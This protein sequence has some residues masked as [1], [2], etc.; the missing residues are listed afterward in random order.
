MKSFKQY[1]IETH[2]PDAKHFWNMGVFNPNG[3]FSPEGRFIDKLDKVPEE[4]PKR[5]FN[6]S[7]GGEEIEGFFGIKSMPKSQSIEYT[8]KAT[9]FGHVGPVW[10]KGSSFNADGSGDKPNHTFLQVE[11]KRITDPGRE[12]ISFVISRVNHKQIADE[13][14]H[15]VF[16]R[17][18]MNTEHMGLSDI[19]AI[20]PH[21]AENLLN[22]H[23][24]TVLPH[25]PYPGA[26]K[27]QTSVE[28]FHYPI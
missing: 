26:N 10:N 6:P 4:L 22:A 21:D 15:H 3:R 12:G 23:M 14:I 5:S 19:F 27:Q 17:D 28:E 25:Y 20:H 1:L 8:G 7:I 13:E 11:S 24:T 16:L 18:D 9:T 2:R